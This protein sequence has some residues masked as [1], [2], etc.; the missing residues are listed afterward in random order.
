MRRLRYTL[1]P[2]DAGR[3]VKSIA[4]RELRLSRGQFSSLKFR[5]GLRVAGRPVRASP[6]G[7]TTRQASSATTGGWTGRCWFGPVRESGLVTGAVV[8]A[9][10]ATVVV[11]G[12]GVSSTGGWTTSGSTDVV[13]G[14]VIVS[15]V[16]AVVGGS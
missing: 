2:Q 5:D 3:T 15:S 8:V 12:S 10:G 7:S 14:S 13:D 11:G 4:L 16:A 6:P 9:G 1:E